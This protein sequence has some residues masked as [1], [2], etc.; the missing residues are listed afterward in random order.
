LLG[1]ES[2]RDASLDQALRSI[3]AHLE[4]LADG[5]IAEAADSDDVTDAESALAF[6][7]IRLR[8]FRTFLDSDPV[9]ATRLW[10]ALRAKI[11]TW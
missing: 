10:R 5:L 2:L 1:D 3:N 6:L 8:T 4:V 7:D 11:N 9:L